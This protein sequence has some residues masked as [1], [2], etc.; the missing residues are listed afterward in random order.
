[1]RNETMVSRW[2]IQPGDGNNIVGVTPPGGESVQLDSDIV[3]IRCQDNEWYITGSPTPHTSGAS[4][5]DEGFASI[6][7]DPTLVWV[8]SDIYSDN[9]FENAVWL[10]ERSNGDVEEVHLKWY[11]N[12]DN[13]IAYDAVG[14][15]W[16]P[17]A[18]YDLS[19]LDASYGD[20]YAGVVYSVEESSTPCVD[21]GGSGEVLN[22][23]W[24]AE[25]TDQLPVFTN[26]LK[27]GSLTIIKMIDPESG[28]YDESQLFTFQV[29]LSNPDGTAVDSNITHEV[30]PYTPPEP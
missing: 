24:E 27:D 5:E 29:E 7:P 12:F 30:T 22:P 26:T 2:I 18:E 3:E 6:S 14:G 20:S 9:D 15:S 16:D 11:G 13:S 4:Y 10:F 1:M 21:C 8:D 17:R 25:S 19:G 28:E 23:N